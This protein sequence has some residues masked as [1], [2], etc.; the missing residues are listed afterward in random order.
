MVGMIHSSG[1]DL[2]S[3]I[4]KSTLIKVCKKK[5]DRG[6]RERGEERERERERGREGE[7]G[8]ERER[9]RDYINCVL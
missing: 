3:S 8:R 5:T 7:R 6:E 9:E 2:R 4:E 1:K